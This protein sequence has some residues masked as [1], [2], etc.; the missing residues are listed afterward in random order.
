M[1][2]KEWD[3]TEKGSDMYW[4]PIMHQAPDWASSYS[5]LC[6]AHTMLRDE[7]NNQNCIDEKTEA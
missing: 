3:M 7:Y 6:L 5:L 1:Y 4:M 2:R